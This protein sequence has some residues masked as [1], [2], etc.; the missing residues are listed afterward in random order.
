MESQPQLLQI[1]LDKK[2]VVYTPDWVARDMVEFFKP[3]GRILEP[4]KGKGAFIKYLPSA[5]W[6]EI[7]EGRDFFEWTDQVDYCF[8]NPP[9]GIAWTWINHSM[10]ISRN[11]IYLLPAWKPF[12]SQRQVNKIREYGGI[13]HCRFY[14]AGQ[15]LNFPMGFAI[16]AFHFQKDY[17][18]PM[19]ISYYERLIDG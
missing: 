5:E 4:C 8:G 16:S 6:C 12:G 11:I 15:K 2:D 19:E 18:G 17:R 13:R 1:A 9:Y 14:G 3:S 10:G 7:S